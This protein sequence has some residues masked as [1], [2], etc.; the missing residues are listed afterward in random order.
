MTIDASTALMNHL[1]A[2]LPDDEFQRWL[3]LLEPVE[4]TQNRVLYEVGQ[5]PSYA[6]FPTTAMVA[7]VIPLENGASTEVALVGNDG[8]VGVSVFM[9]GGCAPDCA[10]VLSAGLGLRLSAAALNE[11]FNRNRKVTREMLGYTQAL[12]AQM[13][14]TIVCNRHHS[15]FER[16][17]RFILLSLDRLQ[18]NELVMTQELIAQMLGV[19]REGVTNAALK[20][21]AAGLIRY[22]RGR[23]KVI[24]RPGLARQSCECY[25]VVRNEYE[26]LMPDLMLGSSAVNRRPRHACLVSAQC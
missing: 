14:Q 7:L 13:S 19:R 11:A 1:L 18:S 20:L 21:Q 17:C 2:A 26:R 12:I 25:A 9:G 16:L 22:F 24:D 4:L 6:Y 15:L 10:V 8:V 23:I 3:P 5:T